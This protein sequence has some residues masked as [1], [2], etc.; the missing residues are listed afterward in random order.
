MIATFPSLPL[1]SCDESTE[2]GSTGAAQK[3]AVERR[4]RK[5]EEGE[6]GGRT[7]VA[8]GGLVAARAIG[9]VLLALGDVLN[10]V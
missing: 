1:R 9:D 3:G 2:N 10:I 8:E 5:R 7:G 4:R 6:E